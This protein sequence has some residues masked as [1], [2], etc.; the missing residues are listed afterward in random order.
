MPA[1][2][3]IADDHEASLRGLE[4]L[5]QLEGY[6]V[7]CAND[8]KGALADFERVRPDLLLLDVDMPNIRGTE[9]CRRIKNNPETMLVPS[10]SLLG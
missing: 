5:L 1:T 9:I 10:Y 7:V 3:L 8:G 2:I 6:E 4:A